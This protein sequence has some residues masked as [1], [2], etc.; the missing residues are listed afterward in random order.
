[1]HCLPA[2]RGE[3]ITADLLD[4]PRSVALEQAENR[5]YVQQAL[6]LRILGAPQAGSVAAGSAG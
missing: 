2:H 4:G 3:E 1:M 6:L 5:M